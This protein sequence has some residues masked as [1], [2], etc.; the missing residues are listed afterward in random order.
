[1]MKK[2]MFCSFCCLLVLVVKGQKLFSDNLLTAASLSK[3]KM[4]NY[5]S[6]CGYAFAGTDQLDD[7]LLTKFAFHLST[8]KNTT[9]SASRHFFREDANGS[10]SITYQTSSLPEFIDLIAQFRNKGFFCYRSIDSLTVGPMLFQHNDVQV[11][12]FIVKDSIK[13][14]GLRVQRE[15]LPEPK[16]LNYADDLLAF[17]SHECL[18]YYFG[19]KNVKSDIYYFTENE[20]TKC[21][22]LFSNTSHQVV[23]IWQDEEN[24]CTISH[25]LFGGQQRLE[26]AKDNNFIAEN[27][28]LFKSGI[29][30]GMPLAGLRK[31][32][33]D[34]L[35]FYGG[36]SANSGSVLPDNTGRLDF[37]KEMVILGCMNCRDDKFLKSAIMN[38]D[39]AIADDRILFVLS[40]ILTP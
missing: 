32:N 39:E 14:Y 26:S 3:P 6:K 5:L 19:K 40:I 2:K 34:D 36:R 10:F 25:L 15:A 37:K 31:L 12:T 1:M 4:Q 13:S 7:T 23:F 24:R 35:K 17:A 18:E 22:V 38:A 29:R 20:L 9:D 8:N 27:K 28:W 16:N 30:A 33:G 11:K 21:S